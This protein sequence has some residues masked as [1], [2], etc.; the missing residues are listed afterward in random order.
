MY[1][2]NDLVVQWIKSLICLHLCGILLSNDKIITIN[3]TTS[4]LKTKS[5]A[6]PFHFQFIITLSKLLT[7]F[8]P[9][10]PGQHRLPSQPAS[11][12]FK[13][14][15]GPGGGEA[16]KN[17][18]L[19]RLTCTQPSL[20]LL[21][22]SSIST[23]WIAHHQTWCYSSC[24]LGCGGRPKPNL[25]KWFNSGH[26]SSWETQRPTSSLR[27]QLSQTKLI[28]LPFTSQH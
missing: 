2:Q 18:W 26:Q 21:H 8:Y 3:W 5:W 10:R 1:A 28:C 11:F 15:G 14:G 20:D 25:T 19:W 4:L 12:D 16:A 17:G 13:L 27:E 23:W 9:F 22:F 24:G 6:S 7:S